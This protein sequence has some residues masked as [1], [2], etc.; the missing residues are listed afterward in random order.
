MKKGSLLVVPFLMLASLACNLELQAEPVTEREE[1]SFKVSGR[2]D[3]ALITFDGSID[4]RSWDRNEVAVTIERR[5]ATAE[6]AKSIEVRSEQNGDHVHVE[7][8]QPRGL[9]VQFGIGP[10][11]NLKVSLPRASNVEA[12]SGDGSI[13][14]D[15]AAAIVDHEDRVPQ[16]VD[17]ECARHRNEI[18]QMKADQ[19]PRRSERRDGEGDGC[20]VDRSDVA[21]V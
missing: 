6:A 11:A 2:P 18:E 20:H 16:I 14:V 5:A 1:K 7:V 3:V 9:N 21:H 8:V 12:R 15:D 13:R 4:V 10:S 19:R 17:D